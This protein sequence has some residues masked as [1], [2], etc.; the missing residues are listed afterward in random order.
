MVSIFPLG[1][2]FV[3]KFSWPITLIAFHICLYINIKQTY[4]FILLTSSSSFTTKYRVPTADSQVSTQTNNIKRKKET[5]IFSL[6]FI[7]MFA[8]AKVQKKACATI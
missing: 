4:N 5:K 2:Y 6:D 8:F 3:S 1:A 7:L